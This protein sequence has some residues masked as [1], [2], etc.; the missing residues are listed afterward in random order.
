MKTLTK[1]EQAI[2]KDPI[3]AA[4][5][6]LSNQ[7]T[8]FFHARVEALATQAKYWDRSEQRNWEW[9]SASDFGPVIAT[10][11]LGEVNEPVVFV[12]VAPRV[13]PTIE[14]AFALWRRDYGPARPQPV[15]PN[16][17]RGWD[18]V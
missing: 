9:V 13:A 18:V 1:A 2:L 4:E 14:E 8:T 16:L 17:S 10:A 11:V 6:A 15:V 12:P 5:R 7:A 3:F